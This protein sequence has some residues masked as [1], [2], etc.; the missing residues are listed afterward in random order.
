MPGT[1]ARRTGIGTSR[2]TGTTT[3]GFAW[4][5]L[6]AQAA[7]AQT[8]GT[9]HFPAPPTGGQKLD[10]G[11]PV[12][13]ANGE[14]SRRPFFVCLLRRRDATTAARLLSASADTPSA[15]SFGW[16]GGCCRDPPAGAGFSRASRSWVS[17]R[18]W[19]DWREDWFARMMSQ[20]VTGSPAEA[21]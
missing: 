20:D 4:P 9:G 7:V 13:V 15:T 12:L 6:R 18:W 10:P 14:R 11:R 2:R 17:T 3:S 21:G 5:Q 19:W 1:A 16:W 8:G